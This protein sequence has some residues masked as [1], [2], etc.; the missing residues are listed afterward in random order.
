[1]IYFTLY[2]VAGGDYTTRTETLTFLAG[3]TSQTVLVN[4][5]DD[6]LSEPLETFGAELSSPNGN[7]LDFSLGGQDTATVDIT[8]NDCETLRL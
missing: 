2:A 8:D 7:G 6:S 5:L 4:T 1:M 3:E